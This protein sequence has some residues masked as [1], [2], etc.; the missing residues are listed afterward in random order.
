MQERIIEEAAPTNF[1]T[2]W[3]PEDRLQVR[4]VPLPPGGGVPD[5]LRSGSFHAGG[6][7]MELISAKVYDEPGSGLHGQKRQVYRLQYVKVSG[8]GLPPLSLREELEKVAN[9][10]GQNGTVRKLAARLELLQSPSATH[11]ALQLRASDIELIP[12]PSGLDGDEMS[13]GCGFIPDAMMLR[14]VGGGTG[15]LKLLRA[16]IDKEGFAGSIK[17]H[18]SNKT[19]EERS[20]A[21]IVDEVDAARGSGRASAA[22]EILQL[23]AVQIR[24]I[25]PGLGVAKGVLMRKP[26]ISKIQIPPSMIKV[27]RSVVPDAEDWVS[28]I[29]TSEFPSRTSGQVGKLVEGGT[30]SKSFEPRELSEMIARQWMGLG[31]PR[32][33]IDDY[34]RLPKGQIKHCWPVGAADPTGGLPA[35]HIFVTGLVGTPALEAL[36]ASRPQQPVELFIT[37]SPCVKPTDGRMLPLVAERPPPM[38]RATWEWLVGLPFGAVLFSTAGQGVPLPSTV[39]DG[40]LDGDL[41]LVCW[42]PNILSHITPRDLTIATQDAKGTNA[43]NSHVDG[44]EGASPSSRAAKTSVALAPE[45]ADVLVPE[46]ATPLVNDDTWLAQVQEHLTDVSKLGERRLTGRLYKQMEKRQV[47]HGMDDADALALGAAYVQSLERPKHGKAILLPAHLHQL[48]Q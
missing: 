22:A 10:R 48:V 5:Q 37:R 26:G 31:V 25:G 45:P 29:V 6:F 35:G 30:P 33:A 38:P 18:T 14:L 32:A 17:K 9:F 11:K 13:D 8:G 1:L 15:A 24:A 34:K 7:A 46:D 44:A 47:E 39:A 42:D 43:N 12:E 20:L 19:G 27:G 23:V 36:R 16:M 3:L 2:Q 28:V 21:D 4:D 41:Y 40:D